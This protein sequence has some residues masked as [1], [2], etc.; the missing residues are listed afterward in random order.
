[1][2]IEM[3]ISFAVHVLHMMCII[4]IVIFVSIMNGFAKAKAEA[5]AEA[6]WILKC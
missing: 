4:N 6:R 3:L 5:E 2:D 1:M